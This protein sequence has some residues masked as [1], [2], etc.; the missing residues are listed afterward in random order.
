MKLKT[1]FRDQF[2]NFTSL[3]HL[4]NLADVPSKIYAVGNID[5]L[6]FPTLTI[7]GSRKMS[8]Y[9]KQVIKG[10]VPTI[11]SVGVCVVS[12]VAYGC[13]FEAQKIATQSGGTTIGIMGCGLNHIKTHQHYKFIK[14]CIDSNRGL[15]LSEFEP[16]TRAAKYTFVKRDRIMAAI[17]N[18]LLVIEAGLK[19]GT[20]HTVNFALELGKEVYAV[21]GNI[22]NSNSLGTNL[23]IQN[24]AN[25][26]L[27]PDDILDQYNLDKNISKVNSLTKEQLKLLK[28]LNNEKT[29]LELARQT[30]QNV[31]TILSQLTLLE[32]Q[33]MV[34]NVGDKW[35]RVKQQS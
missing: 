11:A 35:V 6:N 20:M 31:S 23:L 14:D 24:G 1:I 10:V 27:Q 32:M 29:T 30:K 25:V 4:N 12:G 26:F 19:S 7:I 2:K 15:F 28:L 8:S 33:N 5:L 18:K 22:Y 13:D 3:Q 16:N 17:G 9:G 21:P 34:S